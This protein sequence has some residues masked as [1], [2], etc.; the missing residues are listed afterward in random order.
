LWQWLVYLDFYAS[1]KQV[2]RLNVAMYE[3]ALVQILQSQGRLPDAGASQGNRQWAC[4]ANEAIQINARYVFHR[5]KINGTY[6]SGIIGRHDMRMRQ[7]GG[8]LGLS[9]QTIDVQAGLFATA[10]RQ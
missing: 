7:L 3:P 10:G 2:R 4:E 6:A 9:A 8:S 1:K 5:K